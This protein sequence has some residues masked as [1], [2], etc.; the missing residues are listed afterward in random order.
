METAQGLSLQD[1]AGRLTTGLRASLQRYLE[2][3]FSPQVML[4]LQ[5][6]MA[7]GQPSEKG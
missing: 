4:G 1:K 2:G 3:A 6:C 5:G 7:A